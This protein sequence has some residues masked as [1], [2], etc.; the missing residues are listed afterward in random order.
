[1][2]WKETESLVWHLKATSSLQ[3]FESHLNV[4]CSR[5][6]VFLS[7]CKQVKSPCD[8]IKS[9][10]DIASSEKD[11]RN[12]ITE[13]LLMWWPTSSWSGSS[14]CYFKGTGSFLFPKW[15]QMVLE[16]IKIN[17]TDAS[18]ETYCGG[19]EFGGLWDRWH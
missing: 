1:M 6:F 7:V 15:I 3:Q 12:W 8:K 9:L 18:S 10:T 19:V 16:P 5:Y 14:G 17:K 13:N 2:Y 4:C 11:G